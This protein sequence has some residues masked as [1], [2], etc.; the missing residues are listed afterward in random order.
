MCNLLPEYRFVKEED[1]I[2]NGERQHR[3]GGY[4]HQNWPGF[5]R[6]VP[7]LLDLCPRGT[8]IFLPKN[9]D[10]T[11]QIVPHCGIIR[12]CTTNSLNMPLL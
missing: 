11:L 12:G 1:G 10:K 9:K 4:D 8:I 6:Y 7:Y 5:W 3:Q 2:F